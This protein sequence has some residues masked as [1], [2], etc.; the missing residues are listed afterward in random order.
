MTY[1]LHDD[2]FV[3][4]LSAVESGGRGPSHGIARELHEDEALHPHIH[5]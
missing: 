4:K 2:D 3:S 5:S 1:I